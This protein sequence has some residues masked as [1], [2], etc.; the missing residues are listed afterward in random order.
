MKPPQLYVAY[1]KMR[2]PRTVAV[3]QHALEHKLVASPT[4]RLIT[5]RCSFREGHANFSESST[6]A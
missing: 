5:V 3:V 1:G 2:D 6:T 4:T